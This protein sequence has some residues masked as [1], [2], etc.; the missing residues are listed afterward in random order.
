MNKLAEVVNLPRTPADVPF[1]FKDTGMILF[2]KCHTTGGRADNVIVLPEQIVK[3]ERQL[4][5][6]IFKTGIR[7]RLSATGLIQ[8][9]IDIYS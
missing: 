4:H 6:F 3:T 7:H 1:F 2:H 8:R 5:R 9:I